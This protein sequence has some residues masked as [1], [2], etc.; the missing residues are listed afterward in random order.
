MQ[1]TLPQWLQWL[2]HQHP[3][4]I[5]L[6]LERCGA[7]YRRLGSPRPAK[8]VITVG[9]TNGKG[10]TV[11]YLSGLARALGLE[12]GTYTSPHLLRFNERLAIN[13]VAVSDEQLLEAF[14]QVERVREGVSLT[15]FEFTTLVC[16]AIMSGQKTPV[17]DLAVL[18]V[19]LGGRLDTVNL[20][21]A[22]LTILTSIGLDHQAFLG[23]DRETIGSEKAGILRSGAPLVCAEFA[24]PDSVLNAATALASPV[25]LA[26][27][28]FH[29][30]KHHDQWHFLMDEHDIVIS[31][32]PLRGDHQLLNLGGAMAGALLAIPGF[33]DAQYGEAASK[34][35]Q[36]RLPGRLSVSK[37]D[38]RVF[39]DVGHNPLAAEALAV[40]LD[41]SVKG[42]LHCVLGMYRDK[43]AEGVALALGV[44]VQRWYCATLA[45]DRGQSGEALQARIKQPDGNFN[46]ASFSTVAQALDEA[47]HAAGADDLILVFG[48]FE[49]VAQAFKALGEPAS[50]RENA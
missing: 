47:R 39:M 36:L 45:G 21:D 6:G 16:L 46:S 18:E 14:E 29:W 12:V 24:P 10:S 5:D 28:D 38:S 40:T 17:L 48:S 13:G 32:L 9:G 2:E 7:V 25:Y 23:P 19:G 4:T 11:A 22:D 3:K 37:S 35:T 15:Y 20:V 50:G 33:T 30:Q 44:V 43:D 34:L 27:R 41:G 26:G 49:T 1:R 31:T 42:E 8:T